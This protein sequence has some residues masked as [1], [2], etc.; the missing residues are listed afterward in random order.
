MLSGIGP[1]DHLQELNVT[2]IHEAPGVGRNLQDHVAIGGLNYLITKPANVTDP[3]TF[4]FNLIR[5]LNAHALNLFSRNQ[6]G[7]MYGDTVAEGM[8]FVNTK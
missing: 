4:T 6:T 8:G 3:E 2:V 5:T 1:R 7:P